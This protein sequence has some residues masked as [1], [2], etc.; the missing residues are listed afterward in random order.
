MIDNKLITREDLIELD[1]ELEMISLTLDCMFKAVFTD[2][3]DILKEF[4]ILETEL[5]LD[6]NETTI[7]LLNTELPKENMN[8]CK[9]TIDIFIS[10]NDKFNIDVEL[11]NNNYN[12]IISFRNEQYSSKLFTMS[13]EKGEKIKKAMEKTLIQLNLNTKNLDIPYGDDI[14]MTYG[15]KSNRIY[16]EN[17][18]T[19][20]K[21][22]AY[23]KRLY[24]N[25]GIKL[26]DAQL[27]LVVILSENFVELYD[28]LGNLLTDSKRDKFIRKVIKMSKDTFILHEWEKEKM[29]EL[30]ELAIREDGLIEGREQ[31]LQEGIEQGSRQSK[32]EIA[33]NLLESNISIEIIHQSTGLSIEEINKIKEK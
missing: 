1:K 13:L 31:G 33:K 5:D 30:K 23:Y 16:V 12:D 29:D 7:T 17:K 2:D 25:L 32:I 15:L 14:L 9:K 24:Y 3:L 8:E 6:P 10:L 11:N 4:L 19:I 21:Y 28:L 26:T 18:K 20:L 27:L 22:L